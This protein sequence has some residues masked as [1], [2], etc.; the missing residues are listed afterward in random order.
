M[1]MTSKLYGSVLSQLLSGGIN[2]SSDTI[3]VAGVTSAYTFDQDAHN[4]FDDITNEITG[5]GYTAGGFT[6]TGKSLTY[7]G[8]TNTLKIDGADISAADCTFT[9]AKLVIYKATGTAST[10]PLILCVDLDGDKSPFNAPFGVEWD[11]S[12]I[13]YGSVAA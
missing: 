13:F 2:F 1:A 5:T 11:A 10:S 6:L 9:V 7:D 4:Y 8:A 3:K 12:G